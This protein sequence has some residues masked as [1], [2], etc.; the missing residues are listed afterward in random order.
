MPGLRLTSLPSQRTVLVLCALAC[1]L[2]RGQVACAEAPTPAPVTVPAPASATD[3]YAEFRRAFDAGRYVEAVPAAQRVLALAEQRAQDPAAEEVQ[4]ALMN[5]GLTQHLAADYVAAEA[6]F[7][8]V[9]RL[10]QDSRRPLHQRLARA[11]AWL[12]RTYH[13]GARHDLAV[14]NFEQAIALTRRH[15]GLLTE[16]QVPLIEKYIDSLTELGQYQ[17]ALQAQRYV[18]RIATRKYGADSVELVPTLE[19]IGNWYARVGAYDQAR[20]T[21]RR[22][23]DLVEAAQGVKSPQLIGPLLAIAACD[24]RQLLDPTQ[25][26]V[27]VTPDADRATMFHAP[28]VPEA[29]SYSPTVLLVEAEKSLMRAATIAEERP[30]KSLAQVADV[31]TQLGDWYQG[32]GQVERALPHY[33]VAWQAASGTDARIDGKPLVDALF[34]RPVMLQIARPDAW[35]RYASRPREEIEVR[36]VSIDLTVDP[37]GRPQAGRI[38]DDSGDARRAEKTLGA[39]RT[40]RYR[41]RFEQ[42]QPVATT[43]VVYSQPWIVLIEPPQDAAKPAANA[44]AAQ[45]GSVAPSGR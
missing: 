6:S 35:N 14:V 45:P 34:G 25:Q 23:V 18:L 22:A 16:Q 9:I 5:L 24:R 26:P 4:V 12:A 36:T 41:P 20:R 28:A 2:S 19:Q 43:G 33:Q 39:L 21:L 30:D 11:H 38:V 8:R 10:I 17:V 1:S 3:A 7:L 27:V 37:Q 31:R 42:G 40:A 32:R 15:E 44:P 13:D 29:G